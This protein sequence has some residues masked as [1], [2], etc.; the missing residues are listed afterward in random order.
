MPEL[1]EMET[2]KKLLTPFITTS[3]ITAIEINRAKSVNLAPAQFQQIVVGNNITS[4]ERRAKYLLFHLQSGHVLLLHLMLGGWMFVSQNGESP[5]RTK[6]IILTFGNSTSLYFIG[7]R[8]G[9]LH[10][11]SIK[12]CEEIVNKLGPEPLHPAFTQA[13]FHSKLEKKRSLLKTLLVN[14]QFLSG[15]GNFYSDEILFDAKLLPSRT[16]NTLMESEK[17]TLYHSIKTVLQKAVQFGGYMD[18]PLYETDTLTGSFVK[19]AAVYDHEG[20]PCFR[21]STPIVRT[22]LSSKKCFYCPTCQK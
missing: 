14:Q 22:E 17:L 1:P 16:V 12:E 3:P 8:L 18:H 20:A 5:N 11:L 10:L 15:I 13:D 2:Y 21:C 4:I 19:Q 7:L 6:Q 9:Y